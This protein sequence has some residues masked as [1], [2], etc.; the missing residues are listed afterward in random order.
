MQH[1]WEQ[2]MPILE[3]CKQNDRIGT[4]LPIYLTTPCCEDP[5]HCVGL[6]QLTHFRGVTNGVASLHDAT[7]R[8]VSRLKS[9]QMAVVCPHLELRDAARNQK[10]NARE[11]Y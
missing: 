1:L 9:P 4:P 8:L 7:M 2:A 11:P 10:V 6:G 3:A 5:E